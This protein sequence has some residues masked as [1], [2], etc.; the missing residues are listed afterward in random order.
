MQTI[1]GSGGTIG[2]PLA[3]E[4]KNY[5]D[6]IRLISR[7]PKKVNENDEMVSLDFTQFEG[8]EK[9]I[10]GSAIVYITVGFEYNLSVWQKTWPPFI[11]AT[12]AAC[13]KQGC[14]L[15][16]FDNM[17]MYDRSSLAFMT[18]EASINPCSKKG[19]VRK[20]LVEMIQAADQRGLKT[21][22]ARAADFYGPECKNSLMGETNVKNLLKG[23]KAQALGPIDKIHTY[24]YTPDAA[25]ATALLGNADDA[26]GQAW[27]LPTTKEKLT[28]K[29]W[30]ELVA[31]ELG[32]K[33]DIQKIPVWMLHLLGIFIKPMREFPEMLY[34]GEVDFIFDSSKFEN[35][36][37]LM[38]TSPE[39]GIK[40]MVSWFRTE[41]AK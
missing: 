26:Y 38:T 40:Q 17:Y 41:A 5:T 37:G 22:I 39:E 20:E 30:I 33:P 7:N 15:V 1:L 35:R 9:A 16:F 14:K 31:K 32:V 10:E 24:S 27:H 28:Q 11:K 19:M 4:L 6:H 25:K 18:E 12:I 13:E 23:K 34:M 29:D 3:R 21:L 2:I 8:I 36:F